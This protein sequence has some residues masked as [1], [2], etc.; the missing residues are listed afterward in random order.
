MFFSNAKSHESINAASKSA[1]L[2]STQYNIINKLSYHMQTTRYA[3]QFNL[4]TDFSRAI[5]TQLL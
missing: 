4:F 3:A 1:V 5:L 2:H